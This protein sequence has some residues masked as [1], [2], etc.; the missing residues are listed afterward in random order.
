MEDIAITNKR[1]KRQIGFEKKTIK[2]MIAL[3]CRKNHG[4]KQGLCPDCSD[5]FQ[6]CLARLDRCSWGGGKPAC[7]K[8]PTHCYAPAYRGRVRQVMRFSGPRMIF[9]H[10]LLAIRHLLHECQPVPDAE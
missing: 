6:Y 2:A 4:V 8:C 9:I 5:L 1:E 3:Y 10:P 7:A